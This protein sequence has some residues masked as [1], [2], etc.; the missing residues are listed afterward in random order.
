MRRPD[1]HRVSLILEMTITHM[2]S[3]ATSFPIPHIIG[4][5]LMGGTEQM[6]HA[7]FVWQES[8]HMRATQMTHMPS[9]KPLPIRIPRFRREKKYTPKVFSALK[10]QVPQQAKKRFGVYQKAWSQGKRRTKSIY[11]KEPP[12]CLWGTSSQG[13][14]V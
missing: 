1:F 5:V 11:T 3:L 10:T 7:A 4:H 14:G 8:A 2:K 9:L 12:R 13:I 6:R